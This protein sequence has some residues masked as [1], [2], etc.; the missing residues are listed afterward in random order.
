MDKLL[1]FARVIVQADGGAGRLLAVGGFLLCAAA[2]AYLLA[3]STRMALGV[4]R[5]LVE[6]KAR[7]LA[8]SVD[9]AGHPAL[10]RITPDGADEI[11]REIAQLR[12]DMKRNEERA[13]LRREATAEKFEDLC[14]RILEVRD[15]AMQA[16]KHGG[17]RG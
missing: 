7:R 8:P 4:Q 13:E 1:D 6:R 11:R 3:L 17:R 5:S 12:A 2:A 15:L 14:E 10:P 9:L 16:F